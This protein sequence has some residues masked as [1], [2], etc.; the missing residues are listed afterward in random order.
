VVSAVAG[1]VAGWATSAVAFR[2][3]RH[4]R[5]GDDAA[6]GVRRA[7][8]R[9]GTLRS[10][11]QSAAMPGR[12]RPSARDMAAAE[13]AFLSACDQSASDELAEAAQGYLEV[14]R[15]YASGD[16]DAA[17]AEE[18]AVWRALAALMRRLVR[19]AQSP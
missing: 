7:M 11:Y 5:S 9:L 6:S 8:D 3:E 4:A 13:N 17:A 14:G 12:R 1:G 10:T 16:P 2:R 19:E 18:E 15:A